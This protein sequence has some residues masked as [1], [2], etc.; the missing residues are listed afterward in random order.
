MKSKNVQASD[1]VMCAV[2]VV[3]VVLSV[4]GLGWSNAAQK[5]CSQM[6]A[7]EESVLETVGQVS[8]VVDDASAKGILPVFDSIALSA[9]LNEAAVGEE[10]VAAA[11]AAL[12]VCDTEIDAA[13]Q[14]YQQEKAAAEAAARAAAQAAAASAVHP[15]ILSER[16]SRPGM[17]GR[18]R[19][20]SIGV[21]VAVF[22]SDSQEVANA[23]DSACYFTW[24]GYPVMGDHNYQ[25]WSKMSAFAPGTAIYFDDGSSVQKYVC[26]ANFTGI[27]TGHGFTYED[28]TP[29]EGAPLVLYTCLGADWTH[30][31]FCYFTLA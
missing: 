28:G 11:E 14:K 13:V 24:L 16:A 21:D 29:L 3:A 7:A 15:E 26:T 22:N 12:A 18:L 27:N 31:R 23:A 6:L 25:G 10:S 20:P 30:D 17:M 8:W 2:A 1:T 5:E 9:E 19:M 4:L